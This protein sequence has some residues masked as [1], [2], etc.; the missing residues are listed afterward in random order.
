[1][2]AKQTP[3]CDSVACDDGRDRPLEGG[4][5]R[6]GVYKRLE[7]LHEL[8]PAEEAMGPG[9]DKLRVGQRAR[10]GVAARERLQHELLDRVDL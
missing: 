10:R 6:S 8:R 2:V 7:M 5:G 4:D 1:M 9:D 3:E